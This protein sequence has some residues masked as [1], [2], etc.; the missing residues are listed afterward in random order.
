MAFLDLNLCSSDENINIYSHQ[1]CCS[2]TETPGERGKLAMQNMN[3]EN[4]QPSI[5]NRGQLAIENT[6]PLALEYKLNHFNICTTP[7]DLV[8]I[9]V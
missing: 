3:H 1:N 7:T 4:V 2:L 8:G 5:K 6:P 9:M